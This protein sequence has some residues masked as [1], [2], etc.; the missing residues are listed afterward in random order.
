MAALT[1][2][3]VARRVGMRASALR[4]YEQIGLLPSAQ[5][6]SG[7][8]RYDAAVFHR[9]AVIQR[10]TRLGFSLAETRQLLLAFS[11]AMH[12]SERWQRL[13]RKKLADLEIQ[14]REIRIMRRRLREMIDKCRCVTL[15]QCGKGIFS[16]GGGNSDGDCPPAKRAGAS[17]QKRIPKRIRTGL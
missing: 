1:I 14:A 5:R 16:S 12:A 4:Y 17:N 13:S 6:V 15:D 9:L 2:S 8:R 10:A 11:P 7:Q 3:E